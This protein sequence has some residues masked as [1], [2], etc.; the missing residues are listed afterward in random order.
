ME[1]EIG[2]DYSLK[3][4]APFC[5]VWK[6]DK[7]VSRSG[8]FSMRLEGGIYTVFTPRWKYFNRQG[9]A[10]F[11]SLNQ[12]KP[13]FLLLTAY[14]RCENVLRSDLNKIEDRRNHFICRQSHIYCVHL[15]IDYQDGSWPEIYT[16]SFSP[17]THDWEKR[18]IKVVPE[19]PVKT[20]MVLLEFQQPQGKAW[21]DDISLVELTQP[22]VNLLAYP[23]FEKDESDSDKLNSLAEAYET[24]ITGLIE[25]IDRAI[26]NKRISGTGV[27]KIKNEIDAIACFFSNIKIRSLWQRET[28]DL[29]DAKNWIEMCF[30][31]TNKRQ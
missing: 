4:W 5:Q 10:Q 27:E 14:S 7:D 21:F 18:T 17:G 30:K 3:P 9:A 15:Y 19:K 6:L 23:G 8:G 13:V 2:L 1:K 22:E 31:I 26:Q 25:L 24:K 28:R 12:K 11:L 29:E 20:A 16:A